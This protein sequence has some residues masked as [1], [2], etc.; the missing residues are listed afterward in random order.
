ME[1]H[2][3][4]QIKKKKKNFDPQ[5]TAAIL[6][7]D[8]LDHKIINRE[9]GKSIFFPSALHKIRVFLK[10]IYFFLITKNNV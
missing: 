3:P 1:S 9:N 2:I 5:E 7:A 4:K 6:K 8:V 10:I